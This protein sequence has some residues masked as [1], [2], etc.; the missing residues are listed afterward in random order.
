MNDAAAGGRSVRA[1]VRAG[2]RS[3]CLLGAT[4]WLA[5][6]EAPMPQMYAW[7]GY[8]H[9]IHDSRWRPGAM[10]LEEQI[11]AIEGDRSAAGNAGLRLPP[12]WRVHLAML[13]E[14]QGRTD[15]A[16]SLLLE[17]K[18]NFPS[19]ERLVDRLIDGLGRRDK[20]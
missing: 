6:C 13:Y 3:A 19:S 8:S 9:V 4:L 20:P 16:R 1:C 11:Q 15:L 7:G 5:A 10:P 2:A 17:E 12:G 18:A 14:M